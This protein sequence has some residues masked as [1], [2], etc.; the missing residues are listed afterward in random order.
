MADD[1]LRAAISFVAIIDPV[2]NLLVFA[3]I[4]RGIERR[5]VI[6]MALVSTGAALAIVALFVAA[7]DG[8]LDYMD[9]SKES[10]QIAAGGL[11][12]IPA[13]R[14]V[15]RGEP[16]IAIASE[17]EA[18]G[19]LQLALV[20]LA[21]PLLAGPGALATA[22]TFSG[23]LGRGTTLAAAASVLVATAALFI[24]ANL[25][26]RMVGGPSLRI[27]ARLVGVLLMAI[28]VD[29]IVGGLDVVFA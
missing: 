12:L 21:I 28:A 9:I 6:S 11:L 20:P 2:G 25:I 23:T 10:F 27:A 13:F 15:E 26:V 8:V 19:P 18:A 17:T 24:A 29:L 1:F 4:S 14:L 5:G 16:W 7:G 22:V 3:L